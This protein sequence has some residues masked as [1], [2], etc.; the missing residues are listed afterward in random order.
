VQAGKTPQSSGASSL[1]KHLSCRAIFR[2]ENT[3]CA[4]E[5][6]TCYKIK[7]QFHFGRRSLCLAMVRSDPRKL[8][9]N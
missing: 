2:A 3:F 8:G 6:W 1:S 4:R 9:K 7:E 5:P